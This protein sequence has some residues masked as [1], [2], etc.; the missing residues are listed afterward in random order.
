MPGNPQPI[1]SRV[2]DVSCNVGVV[3]TANVGQTLTTAA[4]DYTGISLNNKVVYTSDATNGSF[5]QR[6]RLKSLGTNAATVARIYMNNGGDQTITNNNILIGEITLPATTATSTT[7][8]IDVDYALN[9]AINPGFMILVGLGT[10]VSA[11]W[12]VSAVGGRY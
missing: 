1:F 12:A 7:A 11:G 6:I 4:A 8:T 9:M 2:G 3:S 10:T 5:I